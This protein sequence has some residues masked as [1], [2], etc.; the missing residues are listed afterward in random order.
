MNLVADGLVWVYALGWSLLHFLWQGAIIGGLFGIVRSQIPKEQSAVRYASG[1]AALA[2]LALSPLVT[3]WLLRPVAGAQVS[4]EGGAV[5]VFTLASATASTADSAS[6]LSALLPWLVLTWMVGVS[7]MFGRAVQQWRAL[8]RIATQFAF[9]HADIELL[10]DRV[11]RRFGGFT[12]VRVLVSQYIDTPTLIGWFNP[13]ILLPTAVVLGF[14]RQQLELILA[15]ELGH[16]R[17]Y[18][19]LVNLG[20]AI[21]ETLL[22]Y[23]P[24]VHWISREVRH[25]REVCCDNLVLRVTEG[26]PREYARTL[27]ALE[28]LRQISPQLAVAATGG[29]LVDRVRRI[30]G[31]P[32]VRHAKQRSNFGIWVVAAATAVCGASAILHLDERVEVDAVRVTEL[33]DPVLRPDTRVDLDFAIASPAAFRFVP[34]QSLLPPIAGVEVASVPV[35][36]IGAPSNTALSVRQDM[37]PPVTPVEPA[38]TPAFAA[39]PPIE[40]PKDVEVAHSPVQPSTGIAAA[41]EVGKKDVRVSPV[42]VRKVAPVYPDANVVGSRGH[43]EFA[44][45]ID[46]EGRVRNISVVSGDS[47]GVFAAAARHALRQWRFEPLSAE[48]ESKRFLLD[49]VFVDVSHIEAENDEQ[50]CVRG[51]GSHLCRP[52]RSSS[53]SVADSNS[54]RSN[55]RTSNLPAFAMKGN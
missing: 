20:Q 49:F 34:L 25:E 12:R 52:V 7:I 41:T 1:L 39:L 50:R 40:S 21:V 47:M 43:V 55:P 35:A 4:T 27:A 38:P 42:V 51:T 53:S 37:H 3:I 44:F 54:G 23:H 22:F 32:V 14:P 8:D 31:S 13:V 10:L 33:F 29:M 16:L 18:D 9:H 15:H 45:A 30:L 24:V 17:R 46:K 19:H 28:D 26:E 11:A 48:N 2:A 5:A 6:V 36:Q